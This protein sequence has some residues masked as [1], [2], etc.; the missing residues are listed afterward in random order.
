MTAALPLLAL[1]LLGRLGPQEAKPAPAAPSLA[2]AAEALAELAA[3]CAVDGGKLWGVPVCGPVLLVDPATRAVAAGQADAEGKLVARDGVFTGT[4]PADKPLANAPVEW[5]GVRWAMVMAPYLGETR[6]ERVALL[7]HESF[8]L[9]QPA[10]G[11]YAFAAETEHLDALE[12]RLWLQ[13]EWNALQAAL[14]APGASAERRAAVQDALDF[15]AARRARFPE[16]GERENALEIREG[17]ASYTGL[18]LAGQGDTEVAAYV[19]ARRAKEQGFVRSFAYF[20]GPLYGYLLDGA[21]PDWRVGLDRTSDLGTRLGEALSLTPN[22][23]RAAERAARHGGDALRA[24]EEARERER[25][26]RLALWRAALVDGPVLVLDLAQVTSGTMDTRKVHAF[27][28]GRTVYTERKLLAKWGVLSVH[29]GALLEDTRTRE[30]RVALT[31]A[32]PDHRSGPGW[33]LE[34]A[35]GWTIAPGVRAGDSTLVSPP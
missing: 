30:G 26:E 16:A 24:A 6:A 9:L 13:L 27:D 20:S 18:R 11:L 5:A 17:L 23:E 22:A 25:R 35:P 8:H 21:R 31:G 19:A 3:A 33:T 2:R 12:G 7:A 10:L 29:D 32:A 15:R 1:A 34:L 4:L 28:E 14:A